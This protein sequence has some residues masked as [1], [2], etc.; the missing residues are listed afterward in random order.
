MVPAAEPRRQT[1]GVAKAVKGGLRDA[2]RQMKQDQVLDPLRHREDFK[3]MIAE[4]EKSWR[5]SN[6]PIDDLRKA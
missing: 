1:A 2:L 4:M 3:K 5:R 6:G